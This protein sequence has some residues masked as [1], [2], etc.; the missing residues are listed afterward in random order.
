[1]SLLLGMAC[2]VAH[3]LRGGKPVSGKKAGRIL[4]ARYHQKLSGAA[5]AGG[6]NTLLGTDT[7]AFDVDQANL[8]TPPIAA[9]RVANGLS[10]RVIA[11]RAETAAK[12]PAALAANQK[13]VRPAGHDGLRCAYAILAHPRDNAA[14]ALRAPAAQC[15]P[16]WMAPDLNCLRM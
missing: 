9:Q 11:L 2:H 5:G 3:A 7:Q 16:Y 8:A 14:R 15:L 12:F 10:Q 13:S 1:M 6:R 4:A